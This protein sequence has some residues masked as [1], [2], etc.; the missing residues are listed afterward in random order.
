MKAYCIFDV[1]EIVD[2]EKLER[3]TQGVLQ[4]VRAHGGRYLNVGGNC[5]LVEGNWAPN[6]LVLI[7]FPNSAKANAWYDS[8]EYAELKKLRIDGARSDAVIVEPEASPLY[9]Q[10]VTGD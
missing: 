2:A 10:L 5:R 4:T 3:Y 6:F 7:E 9:E 8:R 1:C